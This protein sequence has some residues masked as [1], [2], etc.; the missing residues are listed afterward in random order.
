MPISI[1]TRG[2]YKAYIVHMGIAGKAYRKYFPFTE[3]GLEA[4]K[5]R[6]AELAAQ[7]ELHRSVVR[8]RFYADDGRVLGLRLDT[9][10]VK[11]IRG[12]ETTYR[13]RYARKVNGK[14]IDRPM[15]INEKHSVE[16]CFNIM[17]DKIRRDMKI[18]IRDWVII[19][20]GLA[21]AYFIYLK[22]YCDLT[23]QEF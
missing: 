2:K 15:R 20:K 22:E 11:T 5:V 19:R 4:A 7:R 18:D 21:K 12:P 16:H 23:G 8:N 10:A 13:F 3:E 17:V 14:R 9:Y 1:E 6:D